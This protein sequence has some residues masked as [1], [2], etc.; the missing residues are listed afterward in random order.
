MNA[1]LFFNNQPRRKLIPQG[2]PN[3]NMNNIMII[4]ILHYVGSPALG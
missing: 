4:A 3:N 2:Q 1:F